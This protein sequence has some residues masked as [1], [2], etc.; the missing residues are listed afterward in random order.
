MIRGVEK[1]V[2][3]D[4]VLHQGDMQHC[5]SYRSVEMISHGG[6]LWR[7]VRKLGGRKNDDVLAA[8]RFQARKEHY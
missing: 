3:T 4:F 1:Y 7:K 5:S 6:K 8:I 2:G